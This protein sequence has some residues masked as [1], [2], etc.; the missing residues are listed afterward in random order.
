VFETRG[1]FGSL[2]ALAFLLMVAGLLRFSGL[3]RPFVWQD[4][5]LP[6]FVA[7]YEPGYR[8]MITFY[9][10][11]GIIQLAAWVSAFVLTS[12]GVVMTEFWWVAPIAAVGTLQVPMT[13]ALALRLGCRPP[14]ALAAAATMA[15]LPVH[16]MQ[17][18]LTLSHEV[19]AVFWLSAATL[20]ILRLFERPSLWRG[21]WASFC[22][23]VY[24]ASHHYVLPFGIYFLAVCALSAESREGPLFESIRAG[25]VTFLRHGGLLFP[26]L[27]VPVIR[28]SLGYAFVHRQPLPTPDLRPFDLFE[29]IYRCAGA[30]MATVLF[31]AIPLGLA[32]P[33]RNKRAIAFCTVSAGAYLAPLFLSDAPVHHDVTQYS[34]IGSHFMVLAAA[35][36]LD[37]LKLQ[38]T[39]S[40]MFAAMAI[41]V[42]VATLAVAAATVFVGKESSLALALP[43]GAVE[44]DPGVKAAGYFVRRHVD[45]KAQILSV[46]GSFNRYSAAYYM[47]GGNVDGLYVLNDNRLASDRAR[48]FDAFA[49]EVDVVVVSR[50]LVGKVEGDDRFEKA[51]VI[52]CEGEP[53]VWIY[54]RPGM[55]IPRGVADAADF[56][57]GFDSEYAPRSVPLLGRIGFPSVFDSARRVDAFDAGVFTPDGSA[58]KH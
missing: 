1:R 6:A 26:L 29:T 11:G 41:T 20:A 30:P 7:C 58:P 52:Q 23:G 33:G 55:A 49:R 46:H 37:T 13:F 19:L 48:L 24:L 17:S 15:V 14:A 35:L 56:N 45:S 42:W 22:C 50:D 40:L 16:V 53:C 43:K 21:L 9:S 32:R 34:M 27:A 12:V 8:W 25:A 2:V 39:A 18:R 36:A 3:D 47:R 4:E 57:A 54:V 38:R 10:T 5:V 31:I 44:R 51:F 28:L